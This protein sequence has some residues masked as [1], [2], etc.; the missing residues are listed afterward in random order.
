RA[1]GEPACIYLPQRKNPVNL[2]A[3]DPALL[4]VMR[5]RD[6]AHRFAVSYHRLLRKK[7]LTRSI[8]EEVNGIGPKK[9]SRLLKI[10]GSLAA[11]K[12]AGE[13]E[14]Q[15]LGGLDQATAKRLA[16]FLAALDTAQPP[17]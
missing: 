5:L 14:L 8:L 11:V 7:A 12:K 1:T 16:S 3:G 6:E 15:E 2:K 10:F 13:K 17:K 4:L 9:R